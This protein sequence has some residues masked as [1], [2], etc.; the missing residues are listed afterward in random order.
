VQVEDPET[1]RPRLR[2]IQ[3]I[4]TMEEGGP[5]MNQPTTQG[6]P[7]A[8]DDSVADLVTR[9]SQQMSELVRQEL[10]LAQAE[11]TD[12]SRRLG[13]GGGLFGGAALV[14]LLGLLALLAAAIAGLA[15]VLSVWAS[16]LIV[17]SALLVVAAVAAVMG[18]RQ[19]EEASPLVPE[20]T[21]ENVR[22]DLAEIKQEA[23]R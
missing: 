14:A 22:A 23:H 4:A 18:K 6:R 21:V 16:A 2:R 20:R 5:K 3:F 13:L 12:K 19:V 7:G 15:T 10:R 11:M 17:G 9:A 8:S 1:R